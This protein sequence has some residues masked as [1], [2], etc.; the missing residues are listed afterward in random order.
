MSVEKRAHK[1]FA[2]PKNSQVKAT[3]VSKNGGL[4]IEAVVLNVSEGGVG[5]A[6]DKVN[7]GSL[8]RDNELQI[9]S[10][11]SGTGLPCLKGQKVRIKWV[12]DYDQLAN[13]GVGCEFIDLKEECRRE[14]Q[15]FFMKSN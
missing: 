11:A 4:S 14:L 1:R 3:L 12:L 15:E 8:N 10:I 9:E 2:F 5:L 7:N 6:T 13:L